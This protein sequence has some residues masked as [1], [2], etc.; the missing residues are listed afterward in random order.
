MCY[1]RGLGYHLS[2]ATARLLG[3]GQGRRNNGV[4]AVRGGLASG[5]G[6]LLPAT[7]PCLG[8]TAGS[9]TDAQ[10]QCKSVECQQPELVHGEI[11]RCLPRGHR[12]ALRLATS[13]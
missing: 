11:P 6:F 8:L 2:F 1:E 12:E 9:P 4:L 5:S 13:G 3:A 7:A 10:D